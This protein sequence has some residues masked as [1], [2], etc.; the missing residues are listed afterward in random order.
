MPRRK[1]K[2]PFGRTAR[3]KAEKAAHNE[4]QKKRN[5][6]KRM[7]KEKEEAE[8]FAAAIAHQ[9]DE[10]VKKAYRKSP[11]GQ[12]EA[13][14]AK[15]ARELKKLDC[16]VVSSPSHGGAREFDYT[17]QV[18][19]AAKPTASIIMKKG[20]VAVAL[21]GYAIGEA[22]DPERALEAHIES[23][24]RDTWGGQTAANQKK[25]ARRLHFGVPRFYGGRVYLPKYNWCVAR[26]QDPLPP[27]LLARAG[28]RERTRTHAGARTRT[29]V[30]H[31]PSPPLHPCCI[32]PPPLYFETVSPLHLAASCCI[33][34]HPEHPPRC[35]PLHPAASHCIPLHPTASPPSDLLLS[36]SL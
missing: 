20:F 21:A 15:L 7:L 10:Q 17:D 8:A 19:A 4:A 26:A 9:K 33:L 29:L 11:A 30:H 2:N 24:V 12:R 1:K 25:S 14:R 16:T 35:I 22:K 28:A 5:N 34:L 32:P 13:K 3:S 27:R 31:P 6:A 18:A 23:F 36:S